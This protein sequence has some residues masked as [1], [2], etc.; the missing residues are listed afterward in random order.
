MVKGKENI[1]I[2]LVAGIGDLILSSKS[3]RALRNGYP[4]A[5]IHLLTSTEA[6]CLAGNYRYIDHVWSF[7]IREMRT[8]KLVIS[9][10][11][12]VVHKLRRIKFDLI[13]N[14]YLVSSWLG[15]LKMGLLLLTLNAKEKI[16][17]GN[18]CFGLFLT[19]KMPK[20]TFQTRH[21][22]DSMMEI[23]TQG[24]GI[25]DKNG[26]EVFW[27]KKI[28]QNWEYILTKP[29][30]DTKLIGIN[31]GGDRQNRR[32]N[33]ENFAAIGDLLSQHLHSSIFLLG[34]PGEESISQHVQEKMKGKAINLSGRLSLDDLAYVISRLDLLI[35][36][37]SA[38]MHIASATHTPLVA[39]FGPENPVLLG[40]YTSPNL[41]RLFHKNVLCSPCDK[42]QCLDP[43]CLNQITPEEVIKGCLQ[44]LEVSNS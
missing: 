4:D 29:T 40:P 36:N 8:K 25:P 28:E 35:T 31:P 1:L 41:F 16:G 37:D 21:V 2:V 17:H 26:L 5:V 12:K 11:L 18:K 39:I 34:G 7:P 20:N 13:I 43:V 6:S 10:V 32:W 19:K 27:N 15:S 44:L 30:S 42:D 38:P 3:L 9:D 23:A 22:V 24:G 14:L 33:P